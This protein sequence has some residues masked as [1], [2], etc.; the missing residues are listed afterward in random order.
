MFFKFEII[1][2]GLSDLNTKL[3]ATKISAPQSTNFLALLVFT[4]P[5][6]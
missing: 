1:S 4:P 6:I 2:I 5:S 3:P